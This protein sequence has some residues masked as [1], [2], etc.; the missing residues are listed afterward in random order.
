MSVLAPDAE[1]DCPEA[2]LAMIERQA[3]AWITGDFA[4]A[5]PDWHPQGELLAPGARVPLAQMAETIRA[6]HEDCRDLSI[7]VTT[8]FAAPGG[9]LVGLEWSWEVTRR[10]DGARS[11][12]PDGIVVG[13]EGGLIRSWREYFDTAGTVEAR[14]PPA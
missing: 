10:S 13:M 14:R 12:T 7:T 2:V 5:A 9:A 3:R 11:T 8:A 1:I 4:P 6:F